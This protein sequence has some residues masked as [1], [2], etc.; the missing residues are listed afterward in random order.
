MYL[1]R[2]CGWLIGVSLAATLRSRRFSLV[3]GLWAINLYSFDLLLHWSLYLSQGFST[4]HACIG[5]TSRKSVGR[6]GIKNWRP[7]GSF[8]WNPARFVI[9]LRLMSAKETFSCLDG[10]IIMR[11]D[12]ITYR[13]AFQMFIIVSRRWIISSVE[14]PLNWIIP[15]W[16]ITLWRAFSIYTEFLK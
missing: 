9:V 14:G 5:D 2:A 16:L 10:R 1:Q 7:K 8:N 11:G 6:I 13:W 12:W 15:E 3:F 4:S